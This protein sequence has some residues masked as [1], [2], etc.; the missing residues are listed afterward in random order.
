MLLKTNACVA[1]LYTFAALHCTNGHDNNNKRSRILWYNAKNTHTGLGLSNGTLQEL[2]RLASDLT[3]FRALLTPLMVTRVVGTQGHSNVRKHLVDTMEGLNWD[4]E[5]LAFDARTPVGHKTFTNVVATLDPSATR[6]LVIACHYDSKIDTRGDFIGATDSAVPCAMMLHLAAALHSQLS[7]HSLKVSH[8]LHSQLSTHS[9]KVS[10]TLHSQLNT[11]SLKVSH[12]L[13]SQLNTH[14]LKCVKRRILK[15]SLNG[16]EGREKEGNGGNSRKCNKKNR[17]KFWKSLLA[18]WS[19][20]SVREPSARYYRRKG[21]CP[22]NS[23]VP[24]EP[25]ANL[26]LS[27]VTRPQQN[28]KCLGRAKCCQVNQSKYKFTYIPDVQSDLTLQFI[29]FDGEEAFRRWSN[30]D[31]LYGSRNLAARLHNQPYPPNNEDNTHELHRMDLFVLLDLLGTRDVSFYSFFPNTQQWYARM[32][33]FERRLGE[34]QLLNSRPNMFI[35]EALHK[36]GIQDDHIP[37]LKRDVPILHLIPV[38]FPSVWHKLTDNER[39]LH[40]PTIDNLN[41]I[42]FAFTADYLNIVP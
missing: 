3:Q 5:Q 15:K 28:P 4:V 19:D 40:Y 12:T 31:S 39:A 30:T 6:R 27:Q 18:T 23:P 22:G 25:L 36:T 2:S 20:E 17:K 14:S 21:N 11:H 42:L 41:R 33:S 9:L 32:L 1:L 37:F 7:T 34:L 24:S 35:D 26:N 13:H 10:H 8:T 38:P 16:K 29:F